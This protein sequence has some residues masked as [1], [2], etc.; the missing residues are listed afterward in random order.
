MS[1]TAL[2]SLAI[3]GDDFSRVD[4]RAVAAAI[5]EYQQEDGSFA[6]TKDGEVDIRFAYCACAV[7]YVL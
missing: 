6:C 7:A 1:Y 5:G 4:R 3:L 2:A